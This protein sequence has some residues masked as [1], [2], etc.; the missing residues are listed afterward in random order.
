MTISDIYS[1]FTANYLD[2]VEAEYRR[3]GWLIDY[4]GAVV[5][6]RRHSESARFDAGSRRENRINCLTWCGLQGEL[7]ASPARGSSHA[8]QSLL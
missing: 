5:T 8:M 4:D 2:R 3:R 7:V 1:E 6:A